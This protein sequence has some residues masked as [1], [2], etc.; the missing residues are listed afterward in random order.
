[1]LFKLLEWH[2]IPVKCAGWKF[3]SFSIFCQLKLENEPTLL[4]DVSLSSPLTVTGIKVSFSHHANST[5]RT[6]MN[7][8]IEKSII[9]N[10]CSPLTNRYAFKELYWVY[11]FINQIHHP[12]G[13]SIVILKQPHIFGQ[14]V[15]NIL[16]FNRFFFKFQNFKRISTVTNGQ[17]FVF[18]SNLFHN[19]LFWSSRVLCWKIVWTKFFKTKICYFKNTT[20]LNEEIQEIFFIK[21]GFEVTGH[22]FNLA[23]ESRKFILLCSHLLST[24][25]CGTHGCWRFNIRKFCHFVA[26]NLITIRYKWNF[27]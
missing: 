22:F 20:K 8:A 25:L 6:G 24:L 19:Q 11:R 4:F 10:N 2:T 1:M 12:S 14:P 17:I 16:K 26:F 13:Q 5:A 15:Q 3:K 27:A 7:N 21:I 23:I 18:R 9:T